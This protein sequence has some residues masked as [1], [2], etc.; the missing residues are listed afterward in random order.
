MQLIWENSI[1]QF[2]LFVCFIAVIDPL[3]HFFQDFVNIIGFPQ[4]TSSLCVFC[5]Y[6]YALDKQALWIG[7]LLDLYFLLFIIFL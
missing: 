1:R 6:V 5:V 3:F 7:K 2:L 4:Y